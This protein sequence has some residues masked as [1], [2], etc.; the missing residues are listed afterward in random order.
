MFGIPRMH[1]QTYPDIGKASLDDSAF[2]N[3]GGSGD[4][5]GVVS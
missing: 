1:H 2:E 3:V 4:R 5:H